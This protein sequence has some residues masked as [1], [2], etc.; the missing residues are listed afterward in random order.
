MLIAVEGGI[1]EIRGVEA[2]ESPAPTELAANNVTERTV[3]FDE[4]LL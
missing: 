4:L 1:S 3:K 2:S